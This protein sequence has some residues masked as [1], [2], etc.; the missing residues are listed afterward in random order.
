MFRTEAYLEKGKYWS[1]EWAFPW[2]TFELTGPPEP[3]TLW[4]FN[5]AWVK[6]TEP[7]QYAQ[8]SPTYGRALSPWYFGILVFE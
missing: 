6:Q 8:W 3:G 1:I 5:F 2:K 7:A 4:G